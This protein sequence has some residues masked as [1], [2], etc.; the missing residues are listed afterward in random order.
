MLGRQE[1]LAEALVMG[2]RLRDGV[3]WPRLEAL[4]AVR[5]A[6]RLERLGGLVE[7]ADGRLRLTPAGRPLLDAVLRELLA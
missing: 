3:D 6:P 2:L 5:L 1:Q 7:L 4:G